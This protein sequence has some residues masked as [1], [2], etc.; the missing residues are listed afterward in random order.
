MPADPMR[1]LS[2]CRALEEATNAE[3]L[4]LDREEILAIH[5]TLSNL[6]VEIERLLER[7]PFQPAVH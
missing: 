1:I 7:L 6:K 2:F 3:L 5:L 4:A